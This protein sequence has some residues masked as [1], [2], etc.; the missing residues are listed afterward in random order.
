MGVKTRKL[1][2]VNTDIIE[3]Q[4]IKTSD[5]TAVAGEG[6]FINTTSGQVTMT[7]PATA[8][9]GDTIR[10]NDFAGT[11]AT[12]NIIIAR[13]G[14]KI[15]G[16][17]GNGALG[18]NKQT[19]TLVYV[20][21]STGWKVVEN[22]TPE[23]VGASY[24]SA[25]G[26]T[27]TESGDYKVHSF[28]GDGNFVVSSIGNSLG[29]GN[30]VSYLVVAG[31]GGGG[32]QRG[33]GGG[34]GGYREGKEPSDPYAPGASPLA[35]SSGLTLS[36]QTYPI[37]VGGGGTGS[38]DP[39]SGQPNA[40]GTSGSNSVFSTITSAGGGV[41]GNNTPPS[42]MN[43][44][45]G[46]SGGGAGG[47]ACAVGAAGNTPPVSPSQGN[48]GGNDTRPGSPP[49]E[50]GAGGGGAATAGANS[51]MGCAGNG[52]NGTPSTISGSNV[53][54]AGGGGGGTTAPSANGSGGPGGGGEGGNAPPGSDGHA[55]TANT[56]GGGGGSGNT[57]NPSTANGGNG[58]K[59]IVVIRY[60]FQN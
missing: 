48:A 22:V 46:G 29:G 21:V 47:Q 42:H 28:T 37:T 23:T 41:G 54:R 60:K 14:H 56:G 43:G 15:E 49:G 13:N 35:A 3:W 52:G 45:A 8:H 38:N 27:V 24:I 12:N 58:G 30:K 44:I 6:Y 26:G 53:T 7:L 51:V 57:P 36:A 34:A 39:S 31:A 2:N 40:Y 18:T 9:I 17:A 25:A 4:S 55:G 19:A 32:T 11:A 10:I 1:G 16:G 50:G 59:G 20:N 5:F 33:G